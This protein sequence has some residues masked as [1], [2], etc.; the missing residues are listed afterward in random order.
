[1]HLFGR[2]HDH[3]YYFELIREEEQDAQSPEAYILFEINSAMSQLRIRSALSAHQFDRLVGPRCQLQ[4]CRFSDQV[5][6]TSE[7]FGSRSLICIRRTPLIGK[8]VPTNLLEVV[9]SITSLETIL[10]I[11]APVLP[12]VCRGSPPSRQSPGANPFVQHTVDRDQIFDLHAHAAKSWDRRALNYRT[13]LRRAS[14][15]V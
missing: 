14:G 1:M 3:V 8:Y 9:G 5:Q 4:L 7:R 15:V 6:C 13:A 11:E 2:N 10:V 12:S